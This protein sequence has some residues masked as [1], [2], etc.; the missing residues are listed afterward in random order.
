LD[1]VQHTTANTGSTAT[2][3]C[4]CSSTCATLVGPTTTT[5]TT[6]NAACWWANQAATAVVLFRKHSAHSHNT[7]P[8]RVRNR[9]D[10]TTPVTHTQAPYYHPQRPHC[11]KT[12]PHCARRNIQQA[13]RAGAARARLADT[14]QRGVCCWQS[15]YSAVYDVNAFI[16]PQHRKHH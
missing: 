12:S 3:L 8:R 15:Y 1:I 4:L 9:D 13:V 10:C 11:N 14:V 5:T 6:A 7:Q 2:G 16:H